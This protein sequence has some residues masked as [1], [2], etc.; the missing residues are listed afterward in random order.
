[1][2]LPL[3]I[4]SDLACWTFQKSYPPIL[5]VCLKT[6]LKAKTLNRFMLLENSMKYVTCKFLIFFSPNAALAAD[7]ATRGSTTDAR[8]A[9]VLMTGFSDWLK[10]T[11][12]YASGP[13]E[14]EE[15][16]R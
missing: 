15:S 3:W 6:P 5:L 1:M 7:D 9:T 4:L 14:A 16:S 2:Y 13:R 11:G 12:W 8:K 10:G